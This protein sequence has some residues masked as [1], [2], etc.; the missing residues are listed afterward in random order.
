MPTAAS[1]VADSEL[2]SDGSG[3]QNLRKVTFR[4]RLS[5]RSWLARVCT[6][7]GS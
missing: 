3:T 7:G 6:C 4:A 5:R 2:R 1:H